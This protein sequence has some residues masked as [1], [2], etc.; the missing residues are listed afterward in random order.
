[1]AVNTGTVVEIVGD[2]GHLRIHAPLDDVLNFYQFL[3][4]SFNPSPDERRVITVFFT[5]TRIPGSVLRIR[6][7]FTDPL[8]ATTD[9]LGNPVY[10][11]SEDRIVPYREV[12]GKAP[13]QQ[14][15]R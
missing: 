11:T 2:T 14:E 9:T 7:E 5:F 3:S 10:L 1:M 4:G 6:F 12:T 8:L 13:T 15:G